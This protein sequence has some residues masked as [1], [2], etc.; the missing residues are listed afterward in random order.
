MKVVRSIPAE[1][2]SGMG[3]MKMRMRVRLNFVEKFFFRKI[4]RR[5]Y[6]TPSRKGRKGLVRKEMDS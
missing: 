1:V 2:I 6:S 5:I 4:K 3:L